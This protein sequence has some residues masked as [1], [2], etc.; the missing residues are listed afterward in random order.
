MEK[1]IKPIERFKE[2]IQDDKFWEEL[3]K[4]ESK[5]TEFY[6]RYIKKIMALSKKEREA[7][8]QKII[9]KY[10]SDAY[11]RREYRLGYQ[12]RE[13]LFDILYYWAANYGKEAEDEGED[14]YFPIERYIVDDNIKVSAIYGQG[15]KINVSIIH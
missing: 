15:T 13:C 6:E 4:R 7:L 14:D 9:D 2:I 3:E 8:V 10:N 1:N 5:I 11:I 12:P